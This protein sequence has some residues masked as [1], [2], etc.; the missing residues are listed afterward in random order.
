MKMKTTK[1]IY[2]ILTGLFL[3]MMLWSAYGSFTN[4]LMVRKSWPICSIRFTWENCWAFENTGRYCYSRSWLSAIKR[5][6]IRR[7]L[8]SI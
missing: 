6:G 3:A 2:W 1:I 7:F 4:N 5:M 8:L